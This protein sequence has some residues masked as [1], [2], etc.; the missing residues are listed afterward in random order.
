M[1]KYVHDMFASISGKYD[2][3]NDVL[4][5]GIHRLWRKDAL[6]YAGVTKK[7][8][9][10]A[11]DICCGTGDFITSLDSLCHTNSQ[12]TGADF[13]FEM[14]PLAKIKTQSFKNYPLIRADALSLPFHEEKFDI[15]TIGF[16]IRNVDSVDKSLSEVL[17]VLKKGGRIL[18]LEFGQPHIQP[19]NYLFNF[20]S[21]Y[22][23][24]IIGGVVTGNKSAYQYLPETSA[25]F[26]CRTE[27]EDLLKNAGF[28]NTSYKSYFGGIAYAYQGTKL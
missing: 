13:V 27:F 19:F 3:A 25:K 23:M 2:K 4:S 1:S 9:I 18:I 28:K 26:P 7:Y 12:I 20:Y 6:K 16:G 11:L 22:I 15:C 17:R 14:L 10:E 5:F 24:P 8:P 21:K